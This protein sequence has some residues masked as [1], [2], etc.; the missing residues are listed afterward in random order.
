MKHL[1]EEDILLAAKH[2]FTFTV[3]SKPDP[4][5]PWQVVEREVQSLS[6]ALRQ[7]QR[8]DSWEG[9]VF[10]TDGFLYWSSQNPQHFSSAVLQRGQL[11]IQKLNRFETIRWRAFLRVKSDQDVET[12]L[13]QFSA[14]LKL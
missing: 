10:T 11:I 4:D 1:P 6:Q 2:H 13:E 3:A 9:A 14:A 8:L 5:Q 7:A 12:K